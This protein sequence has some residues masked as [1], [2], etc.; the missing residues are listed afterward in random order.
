MNEMVAAVYVYPSKYI[1]CLSPLNEHAITLILLG[2]V[3]ALLT[4]IQIQVKAYFT[5]EI[6]P[7]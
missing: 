6:E 5:L 1:S 7:F 2:H 3:Q 4:S